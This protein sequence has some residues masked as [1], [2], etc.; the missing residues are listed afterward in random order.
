MSVAADRREPLALFLS[1]ALQ[2]VRL[3]P[4]SSR[5][6]RDPEEHFA[7]IRARGAPPGLRIPAGFRF[8]GLHAE[9]VHA[10]RENHALDF[11]D[12]VI[13]VNRLFQFHPP[14]LRRW[15]S[16]F[17]WIQVDEVQDTNRSEYRILRALAQPHRRLSFFGDVDQTIYEW[18][19]SVPAEILTAY[20]QEFAPV[21]EIVFNQ[22][23]RSTR[24]IL[25]ACAGVIH[26][27]GEP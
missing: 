15:Q 5:A 14:A 11:A 19:G 2:E 21:G 12:L 25:R 3:A 20:R 17:Q 18:R 10:L 6:A 1:N 22:N 4:F 24:A 8:A 16:R 7:D 23:Y 27:L 13:G 9:Y 26:A